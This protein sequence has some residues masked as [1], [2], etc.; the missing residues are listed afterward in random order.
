MIICGN[1]NAARDVSF[2]IVRIL[3]FFEDSICGARNHAMTGSW[4]SSVAFSRYTMIRM[5]QD[6]YV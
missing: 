4:E 1:D 3:K 5:A 2:I 6:I